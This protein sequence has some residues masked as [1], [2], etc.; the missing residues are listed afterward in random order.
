MFGATQCVSVLAGAAALL[1]LSVLT[2]LPTQATESSRRATQV[3]S[4]CVEAPVPKCL[5]AD[6]QVAAML[7]E[8]NRSALSALAFVQEVQALTGDRTVA[9]DSLRVGE[10]RVLGAGPELLANY[11]AAV[12]DAWAMLKDEA[13]TKAA[14]DAT[15]DNVA[16]AGE[17]GR[18][19]ALA[20]IAFA[21]TL[22]GDN[23][24]AA[25]SNARAITEARPSAS[26]PFL[27]AYVGW[28]QVFAGNP[29]AGLSTI[30]EALAALNALQDPDDWIAPW[31]LGY[32]S[33]GQALAHDAAAAATRDRLR[34]VVAASET[35][36]TA[37]DVQFMLAWSDAIAGN[38]DQTEAILRAH[39]REAYAAG[40]ETKA[41]A[42]CFAAL[43]LSQSVR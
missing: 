8:D 32:A 2:A 34:Q 41:V 29:Q 27:L 36:D 12:A 23:A 25:A 43:A 13:K 3:A 15:L 21:Q 16:A 33:I 11:H 7:I 4:A 30:Q 6:A 20:D 31:T 19:L 22:I 26:G 38:R 18:G 9:L 37:L 14:I 10:V 40:N 1:E 17:Y 24:G 39:L 5:L 35:S 42:L 28:N